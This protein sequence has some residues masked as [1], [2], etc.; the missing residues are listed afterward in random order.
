MPGNDYIWWKTTINNISPTESNGLRASAAVTYNEGY[1]KKGNFYKAEKGTVHFYEGN[2]IVV[3]T[4]SDTFPSSSETKWKELGGRQQSDG[5]LFHLN[6]TEP[7][8]VHQSLDTTD[9]YLPRASKR[10]RLSRSSRPRESET[11]SKISTARDNGTASALAAA[12]SQTRVDEQRHLRVCVSIMQ[13]QLF[14]LQDKVAAMQSSKE[15]QKINSAVLRV[16]KYIKHELYRHIR[17]TPTRYTGECTTNFFSLLRRAPIQFSVN[18]T[19][20]EFADIASDVNERRIPSVTYL[21]SL[22]YIKTRS[23][24]LHQK[25]ICFDSFRVLLSWLGITDTAAANQL[26]I[27][28][29]ERKAIKTIQIIGGAQWIDNSPEAPLYVFLGH[30]CARESPNVKECPELVHVVQSSSGNVTN[31]HNMADANANKLADAVVESTATGQQQAGCPTVKEDPEII[32]SFPEKLDDSASKHTSG[33]DCAESTE[34]H[35][36]VGNDLD[37]T[38]KLTGP[39]SSSSNDNFQTASLVT[40]AAAVSSNISSISLPNTEWDEDNGSFRVDFEVSK[41][42]QHMDLLSMNSVYEFDCFTMTWRPLSGLRP[43]DISELDKADVLGKLVVHV[44]AV[45]F[46]GAPTCS[47][48]NYLLG[49]D[50]SDILFSDK[51][52]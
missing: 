10:R 30:S 39:K 32:Q 24:P 38:S 16:K 14:I 23:Q 40:K 1:D 27:R 11:Q 50:Q 15:N 43:Q 35:T 19:L 42:N 49:K 3:S 44:P 18:C 33:Q 25:H 37:N 48:I 51:T 52:E 45:I 2:K 22:F 13:R 8:N 7:S 4:E 9:E 28:N 17:R 6:D 26:L 20:E 31:A 21:P 29:T 36:V 34:F 47:R 41:G 5:T 46:T 12:S